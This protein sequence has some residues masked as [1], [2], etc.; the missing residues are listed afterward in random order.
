MKQAADRTRAAV[1][2]TWR[3]REPFRFSEELTR[4]SGWQVETVGGFFPRRQTRLTKAL[5]I[6]PQYLL[7]ALRLLLRAGRYH[8]IICWQ[9]VYGIALALAIRGLR[10]RI[11]T[12]I[13]ILTFILTPGKRR[14]LWR[15][16]IRFALGCTNVRAVVVHNDAELDLYRSLFPESARKFHQATYTAADVPGLARYPI[17][18]EGFYLA[19]GR[20]NRD[21][22]FLTDYFMH[23]Q[24]RRLVILCDAPEVRPPGKNVIVLRNIF[25]ARYYDYLSRCHAVL[26]TFKDPTVSAGQLVFLQALQFGKPIVA[27]RSHC[28]DGYLED[29]RNGLLCDKTADGLDAA[30]RRL[31]DPSARERLAQAGP[32]DYARRFGF[33]PLAR[34]V[35]AIIDET[36]RGVSRG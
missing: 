30:L 2:V 9:Q 26:L 19:V 8:R 17:L 14:G 10:L 22:E 29:G 35:L 34:R 6:W 28:L 13:V 16:L 3:L 32:A 4:L 1:A 24:D 27:T 23:R 25:G 15:Q 20:S 31:Q 5:V 7:V 21:Y 12:R 11:D 18:D 33:E 36:E